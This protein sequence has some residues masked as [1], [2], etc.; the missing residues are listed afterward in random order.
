M[1]T[2]ESVKEIEAEPV[3]AEAVEVEEVTEAAEEIETDEEAGE[4]VVTFGDDETPEV[5]DETPAPEWV[6]TLR[7]TNREQAREIANLKKGAAKADEEPSQLSAKPTLEGSD[8]DEAK[9]TESLE[10]WHVQKRKHDE[11]AAAKEKA[12]KDQATAWQNRHGEY[13]EGKSSFSA[14]VIEDAEAVAREVLS[15]TQQGVLIEALGKG[16]AALLVGLSN[17]EKRLKALSNIKN[18]IRFA[19]AARDLESIMKTTTRRP[20]TVPETIVNGSASGKVGDK[21]LEAL[22]AEA[23]K[24]GDRTKVL[25]HKRRVREA[26][27]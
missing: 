20:K 16:A 5:E 11:S 26:N 13:V 9:F 8:Y 7:K 25:A 12:D 21:A 3:I 19:V 17:D 4:S 15:E 6:K 1:D 24:T 18:P 2:I 14:D 23:D 22:E 10:N 27:K